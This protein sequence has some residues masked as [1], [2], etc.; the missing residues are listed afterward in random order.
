MFV[1]TARRVADTFAAVNSVTVLLDASRAA[2][3]G[4]AP[5]VLACRCRECERPGRCLDPH[6]HPAPAAGL[7][8]AEVLELHD[9]SMVALPETSVALPTSA[10]RRHHC[11]PTSRVLR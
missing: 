6:G 2:V 7:H 5:V 1:Q 10:R 4:T 11:P 8:G 3:S 9:R